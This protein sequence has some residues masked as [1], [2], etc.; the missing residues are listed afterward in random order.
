M[1]P[2]LEPDIK[3]FN[4]MPENQFRVCKVETATFCQ[5]CR[6]ANLSDVELRLFNKLLDRVFQDK[7]AA[8]ISSQ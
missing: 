6:R 2:E 4:T 3:L 7:P 5:W 1:E 8:L